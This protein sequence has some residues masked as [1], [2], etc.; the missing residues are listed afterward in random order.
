[1]CLKSLLR[2]IRDCPNL[3]GVIDMKVER[4]VER[5]ENIRKELVKVSKEKIPL[6]QKYRYHSFKCPLKHDHYIL[7]QMIFGMRYCVWSC[8]FCGE[9]FSE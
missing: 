2:F 3:A 8:G 9:E 1:M 7:S 5:F 6:T 4:M